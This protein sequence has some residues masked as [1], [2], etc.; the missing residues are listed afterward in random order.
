[1]VHYMVITYFRV[2]LLNHGLFAFDDIELTLPGL[3][4]LLA[5]Q[6]VD[7][8]LHLLLRK[9]GGDTSCRIF[10]SDTSSCSRR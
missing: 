8:L 3:L 10:N 5:V 9:D 6:V 4:H 1:M 7:T 2:F